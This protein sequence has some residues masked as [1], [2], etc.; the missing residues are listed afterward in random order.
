MR[1]LGRWWPAAILV[2]VLAIAPPAWA[3]AVADASPGH[4][5]EG[6]C[7]RWMEKLRLREAKNL[8]TARIVKNGTGYVGE[9]KGYGRRALRCRARATGS[10]STPWVGQLVYE[11]IVYRKRGKSLDA[12]R[13]SKP[14]IAA[15]THVLEIFKF[16]GSRWVY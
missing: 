5:F 11:E 4:D 13:S 14:E 10:P 2:A 3:E 16:D 15:R 9:F 1:Q 8:R 12:A 7:S 6:F